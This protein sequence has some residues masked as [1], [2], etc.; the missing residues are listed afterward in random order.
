MKR[1][2]I[3]FL[4]FMLVF[5]SYAELFIP[6]VQAEETKSYNSNI[7]ELEA[8]KEHEN[9]IE[10]KVTV[11]KDSKELDTDR[12]VLK[13]SN[14]LNMSQNFN[15]IL[16]EKNIILKEVQQ[17]SYILEL[18]STDKK[19]SFKFF[20]DK[21]DNPSKNYEVSAHMTVD[22]QK[23]YDEDFVYAKDDI[24]GSI[25]YKNFPE[26]IEKKDTYVY[27]INNATGGYVS[28][29]NVSSND[30]EFTFEDVILYDEYNNKINYGLI[31]DDIANYDTEINSFNVTQ[32]Y[33]T[34]DLKGS[35]ENKLKKAFEL[36]VVDKT[37]DQVVETKEVSSNDTS[38]EI[39]DLPKFN[40]NNVEIQYEVK[41]DAGK[42][43]TTEVKDGEIV[44]SEKKESEEKKESDAKEDSKK[45]DSKDEA[46]KEDSKSKESEA[47]E[48]TEKIEE[49]IQTR[50]IA[51]MAVSGGTTGRYKFTKQDYTL[52][53]GSMANTLT[54]EVT[55]N[56]KE[57]SGEID[58][59]ISFSFK[60]ILTR[61]LILEDIVVSEGL[62]ITSIKLNG[63]TVK[64]LNEV[65]LKDAIGKKPT[66]V[67]I[68]TK[69]IDDEAPIHRLDI[70]NVKAKR[71]WGS[72]Y[73]TD[74]KIWAQYQMYTA[75]PEITKEVN[76]A[77]N[78][79]VGK[80]EPNS[81]VKV[82]N[83]DNEQIGEETA[84]NEG[85]FSVKI[86]QQKP[87]TELK[88]TA[89]APDK[90]ESDSV[91]IT[92]VYNEDA[93][94]TP[95]TVE[96]FYEGETSI[97]G[98]T[99]PNTRVVITDL[100]GNELGSNQAVPLED[101]DGNVVGYRYLFYVELPKDREFPAGTE[102]IAYAVSIDDEN[103]KSD[104]VRFT[105]KKLDGGS[106]PQ[107]ILDQRQ[108]PYP[109]YKGK[110]E[111]MA[112]DERTFHR[113][114]TPQPVEYKEGFLWKG[115]R[116][117]GVE[118]EFEIDLKTQGRSDISTQPL[119]IVLV[120][121]NSGS[122]NQKRWAWENSRWQAMEDVL[123][124]F[125]EN[126]TAPGNDTR[127]AVVN[128]GT[129]IVSE[130]GFSSDY[131]VIKN[132]YISRGPQSAWGSK[133][134]TNTQLG[135]IRGA[136][137]IKQARPEAKK[138]M[139]LLTDGAPTYSYKGLEATDPENITKFD[140]ST[141][142]GRGTSFNLNQWQ[143]FMYHRY[144]IGDM[145]I[146]DH[147]QPTISE[148]KLL[149]QQ[150]PEMTV[151]SVG[152]D[153]DLDTHYSNTAQ[154]THVITEVASKP[155]YAYNTKDILDEDEGLNAI[156]ESI[157]KSITKSI[158]GGIVTD[159]IGD[160]YD[161]DLG[162][163]GEFDE[164]DYELT[165]YNDELL[166]GVSV[167]YNSD[168]RVLEIHGLELG[169]GEWVNLN[170]KVKLKVDD[171]KF[172]DNK[173]YPMNGDTFLKPTPKSE[174]LREYPVPEG[175][176]AKDVY[177]FEILKTDENKEPL[178]GAVFRLS[179]EDY[180]EEFTSN[181]DGIVAMSN[182]PAGD[183]TLSESKAPDGYTKS[184]ET[185]EISI[186]D[187]GKITIDGNEY[188]RKNLLTVENKKE[189]EFGSVKVIKHEA[190]DKDKRL[191][192]AKFE[193]RPKAE[194]NDEIYKGTTN[195]DGEI[196][197]TEIPFGEYELIE[198]KAPDGYKLDKTP[199]DITVDSENIEQTIEVE[200]EKN[201]LP[202]TGGIGTIIFTLIGLVLISFGF[203]RL[204][205]RKTK[206]S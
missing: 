118:N 190:G 39:K 176:N 189:P 129:D 6:A 88:V 206:Y 114:R 71:L 137:Y 58:W 169:V 191:D 36:N 138:V 183:Y 171:P 16:N 12:L 102:L 51:P 79:I 40:E 45:E 89:T 106:L 68:T 62:R 177:E 49:K 152:L 67:T 26:N 93:P 33:Q 100:E 192:G 3:I 184:N 37:S 97:R 163:N 92:V 95:V 43:A 32:T 105:V 151:F 48:E 130:H 83:S 121:D 115:A 140:Y 128:Y 144:S 202:N 175:R 7:L 187:K 24:K 56:F 20:T 145:R 84:D 44:I 197:F 75:N 201:E 76:Q 117:T 150:I 173:W 143:E 73:D 124:P 170:Y 30:K 94:L 61:Y 199:R 165:A 101:E 182:I 172:E 148:A 149:K 41:A 196:N 200:N 27:L 80:S 22:N 15:A 147:G 25:D 72:Y 157:Q 195:E 55:G 14:D 53:D 17:T 158:A 127:F 85:K 54:G 2:G 52:K 112:W 65:D 180:S 193:L 160:M 47:K 103:E 162:P 13:L 19:A 107:N 141:R 188:E 203:Y 4:I 139:I 159:P 198:T 126:M 60:G 9:S 74:N 185:Y 77:S 23:F 69:I 116:A 1:L 28:E 38:Y 179:N 46:K 82:Y 98:L 104:P 166:E 110:I 154:R 11:N 35:I 34:V 119:D 59:N 50:S 90:L 10:W 108:N 63:R 186:S 136:D 87:E 113:N 96:D 204:Y 64:S 122:M 66:I 135:L 78:T 5:S 153:L 29:K 164:S 167:K 181:E 125:I 168:K 21:G 133:G 174:E 111:D 146:T 18:P 91:N 142:L 99:D 123:Y 161:L 134:G 57:S 156:L 178:K 155:E 31:A 120:I 81:V 131:N 205:N 70:N 8:V 132:R 194:D 86:Q 109:T 42:D